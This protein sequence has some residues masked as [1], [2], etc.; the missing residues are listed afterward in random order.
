V[1]SSLPA[2]AFLILVFTVVSYLIVVSTVA[3]LILVSA[4]VPLLIVVLVLACR[5]VSY[6][7][8]DYR[9]VCY[10]MSCYR[11]LSRFLSLSLPSHRR[12]S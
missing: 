9:I 12:L 11:G 7:C 1:T 4:I 2:V 8:L 5:R 6:P 3:F 10:R